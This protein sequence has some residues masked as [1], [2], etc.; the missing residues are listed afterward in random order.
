[1]KKNSTFKLTAYRKMVV[2]IALFIFILSLNG[3]GEAKQESKMTT[4]E[5]STEKYDAI[6]VD[7]P[8]FD[9]DPGV[10]ITETT[11]EATTE[12]TTES[13][14]EV[15]TE[16]T[17]EATTSAPTGQYS[18]DIDGH[19]I[20]LHTNI[21]DYIVYSAQYSSY[22][23]DIAGI[24]KSLG[25]EPTSPSKEV[26]KQLAF[27]SSDGESTISFQEENNQ[28]LYQVYLSSFGV[29]TTVHFSR[30]DA[31]DNSMPV[32]WVSL[33]DDACFKINYEQVIIFT[34]LIENCV[35]DPNNKW[36]NNL[37]FPTVS[38]TGGGF[39]VSR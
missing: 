8:D 3:C 33:E 13:T 26:R 11:T 4:E 9:I 21:D 29:G 15:T 2:S 10:N 12:T 25:F 23:V 22:G 6:Q 39:I 1:M 19:I 5:L 35:Y 28:N 17:T 27:V 14:A 24:A 20:N 32:Y 30:E 16:A 37:G 7:E 34:F 18:Y 38:D 36:F 31:L